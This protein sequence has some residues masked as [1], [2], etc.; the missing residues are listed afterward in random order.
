MPKI[1]SLAFFPEPERPDPPGAEAHVWRADLDEPRWPGA[2]RLPEDER[3]RAADI[4]SP[5]SRRRWVASRWA[6]RGVLSLYLDL[7][8]A[9]LHLGA[10]EGGKPHLAEPAAGVAF[11]LSHSEAVA[12]IAV[13]A[14][15]EVGVDVQR[16]LAKRPR[17][18]YEDW[19]E[20]EARLKCL[21]T[22]LAGPPPP[23]AAK[24]A[25]RRLDL[26]PAYAASIALADPPAAL[27]CWTIDPPLRCTVGGVS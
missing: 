10:G 25:A 13:A 14:G 21:G 4:L 8:P 18:F 1:R 26:G 3:Q 20:R 27:R 9:E 19:A 5:R 15:G 17:A 2:E 16:I 24:L 11:N 7:P 6:L 23:E 12:L 22:G